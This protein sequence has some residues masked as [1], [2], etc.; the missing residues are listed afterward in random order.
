[1]GEIEFSP[2][3]ENPVK[4]SLLYS[5]GLL[6]ASIFDRSAHANCLRFR[7]RAMNWIFFKGF[8]IQIANLNRGDAVNFN[9]VLEGPRV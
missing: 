9:I 8:G 2:P 5:K 3:V 1:M 7:A 6:I 4:R